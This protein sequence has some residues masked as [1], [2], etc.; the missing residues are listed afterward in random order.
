MALRCRKHN[1]TPFS[2]YLD[3]VYEQ[4]NVNRVLLDEKEHTKHKHSAKKKGSNQSTMVAYHR[5]YLETIPNLSQDASLERTTL[6]FGIPSKCARIFLYTVFSSK[7]Q[8][9]HDFE[10]IDNERK[11]RRLNR[12]SI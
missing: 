1:K 12:S 5:R 4:G 11:Q 7:L 9:L 3:T 2:N 8:K 10:Q 6:F